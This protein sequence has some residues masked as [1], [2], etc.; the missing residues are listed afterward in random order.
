MT[1]SRAHFSTLIKY[2]GI[3]FITGA[4]SHWFFSGT[5]SLLTGA[6]G[7]FCFIIWTLLEED[8]TNTWQTIIAGTILAVGIGSVTGGLQHFPDSP[9]RSVLIIPIGYIISVLFFASIHKYILTKKEYFYIS[10]SS[11]FMLVLSIGIFFLIENT[12]ITWHSHDNVI[13]SEKI[14]ETLIKKSDKQNIITVD[15]ETI[16]WHHD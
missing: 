12:G 2:I 3:S 10:I 8:T 15:P 9:E 7:I 16:P 14:N 6:F 13:Q 5:R 11:I 1:F 4:I